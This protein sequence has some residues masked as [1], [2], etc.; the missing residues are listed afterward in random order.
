MTNMS[1]E[2]IA[3]LVK[4]L[5][6]EN[7]QKSVTETVR[8][9]ILEIKQKQA[10]SY[11]NIAK[12]SVTEAVKKIISEKSERKKIALI[13]PIVQKKI[14][15]YSDIVSAPPPKKIKSEVP[16]KIPSYSEIVVS[17]PP[18]KK[19]VQKI[20]PKEII[21]AGVAYYTHDSVLL[22]GILYPSTTMLWSIPKG[23]LNGEETT[24]E[25]AERE[26]YE[27]TG[28]RVQLKNDAEI[29]RKLWY[30][31]KQEYE[32]ISVFVHKVDSET[33]VNIENVPDKKEIKAIGW[34]KIEDIL[35]KKVNCNHI[36]DKIIKGRVIRK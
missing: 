33:E 3:E 28:L 31:N 29:K 5:I 35:N 11:S 26:F 34:F 13:E 14:P 4:K 12:K 23:S 17:T 18:P 22:V 8:K 7:R 20:S 10:K 25:T 2:T 1:P 32:H 21:K 27:E 9:I 36:T 24:V 6:A 16:K 15:S 19:I 30:S